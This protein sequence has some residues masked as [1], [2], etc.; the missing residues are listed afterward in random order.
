MSQ[1]STKM[2]TVQYR[3]IKTQI[4]KDVYIRRLGFNAKKVSIVN[5]H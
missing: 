4:P 3:E 1:S 5:A 2:Y